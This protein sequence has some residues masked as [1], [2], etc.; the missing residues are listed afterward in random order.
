MSIWSKSL[1]VYF[2]FN[3][4]GCAEARPWKKWVIFTVLDKTWELFG[5]LL[6]VNPPFCSGV[7][8]WQCHPSVSSASDFPQLNCVCF[9]FGPPRCLVGTLGLATVPWPVPFTLI[10]LPVPAGEWER[11]CIR[12]VAFVGKGNLN[13]NF[14]HRLTESQNGL[15]GR[16]PL[17]FILPLA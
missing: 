3:L 1:L 9:V 4:V 5:N 10:P 11:W 14:I 2:S 7:S 6:M 13:N 17:K 12:N 16:G 15:A 8:C